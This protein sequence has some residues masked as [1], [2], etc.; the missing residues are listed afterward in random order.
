MNISEIAKKTG[1]TS[2]AIRFYE[3]KGLIT[4]A[5]RADNGYRIYGQ[6]QVDELTFL[7]KARQAGFTLL[8]CGELLQL[9][10]DP[11][12]H[13]ADVKARTLQKVDDIE[14]HIRVLQDMRHQLLTL[15]EACPGD[16]GAFCPILDGLSGCGHKKTR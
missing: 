4:A 15:A 5:C 10:Q 11:A 13:S 2:K 3:Q 8:E 12:R 7:H 1:L 16:E 6:K 14:K 9:L